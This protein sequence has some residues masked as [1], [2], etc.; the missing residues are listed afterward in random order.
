VSRLW[1]LFR[2]QYPSSLKGGMVIM[3]RPVGPTR[4]PLPTA[5]AERQAHIRAELER[6]GILDTEPHGW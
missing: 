3:G 1:A 5:S 4:P 6:L 2:N